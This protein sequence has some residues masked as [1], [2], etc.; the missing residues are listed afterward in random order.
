MDAFQLRCTSADLVLQ[1]QIPLHAIILLGMEFLFYIVALVL[2]LNICSISVTTAISSNK[3]LLSVLSDFN[4]ISSLNCAMLNSQVG[5]TG[6]LLAAPNPDMSCCYSRTVPVWYFI[7][8][9]FYLGPC[10]LL[11]RSCGSGRLAPHPVLSSPTITMFS[12]NKEPRATL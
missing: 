3:P 8:I 5:A 1:V 4:L 9:V 10:V 7:F 6:S 12:Q 2:L 11:K